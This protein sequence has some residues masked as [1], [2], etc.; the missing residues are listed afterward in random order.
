MFL[1]SYFSTVGER[2]LQ[3]S[4]SNNKPK[5]SPSVFYDKPVTDSMFCWPV[6][7]EEIRQLIY[8]L[9][10]SKSPGYDNIGASLIIEVV[11]GLVR[12]LVYIYNL[13]IETGIFPEN[14]KLL[15]LFQ[16][17]KKVMRVWLVT[18]DLFLY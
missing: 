6:Y 12:P 9:K 18:I 5:I 14:L 11:E 10:I 13:S 15:K 17:I 7:L 1:N 16:P 8:N 2:L 3:Q 4:T